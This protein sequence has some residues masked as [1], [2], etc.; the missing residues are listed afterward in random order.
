[1]AASRTCR[2]GAAGRVEHEQ[3]ESPLY[4]PPVDAPPIVGTGERLQERPMA[5]KAPVPGGASPCTTFLGPTRRAR[6]SYARVP[7]SRLGG[8]PSVR[9]TMAVNA[10]ALA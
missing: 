3:G 10:L 7:N 9:V 5:A 1:M 8:A 4:V 6:T 2:S